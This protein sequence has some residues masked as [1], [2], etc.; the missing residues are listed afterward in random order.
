MKIIL[1]LCCAAIAS[2][3]LALTT[4]PSTNLDK[5]EAQ[6][7]VHVAQLQ[8][9]IEA[10]PAPQIACSSLV[11]LGDCSNYSSWDPL[12]ECTDCDVPDPYGYCDFLG[13]ANLV[14]MACY[15]G[16][17]ICGYDLNNICT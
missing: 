12:S 3:V 6:S 5:I 2:A 8:S 9:L 1:A 14:V 4:P 7:P 10:A 13:L 15:N 17:N 11:D 16:A